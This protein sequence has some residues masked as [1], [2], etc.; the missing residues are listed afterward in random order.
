V[1]SWSQDAPCQ[2]LENTQ[3]QKL[4]EELATAKRLDVQPM[5]VDDPGFEEVANAGLVKWA[6]TEHGELLFVPHSVG[7]EE[8]A[9][10]VLTNG[11]PVL[12]AGV[13]DLAVDSHEIDGFLISNQSSHYLTDKKSLEIG[14]QAFQALGVTFRYVQDCSG[15]VDGDGQRHS[16][17]P[18]HQYEQHEDSPARDR[19]LWDLERSPREGFDQQASTN[20][21]SHKDIEL[22][23]ERLRQV[24]ADWLKAGPCKLL[25]NTQAQ[26]LSE[27]LETAKRLGVHPM[28]VDDPGFEEVANAGLIKWAVTQHGELLVMAHSVGTEEIAHPVLT[29]GE[30]VLAAGVAD[31]AVDSHGPFGFLISNQSRRS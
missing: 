3:A 4:S 13:A 1:D 9:H 20:H 12:A 16:S 11:E 24:G 31:L 29:N 25:E 23:S 26:K 27:D 14:Q 22:L 8:I 18:D 21:T 30:P 5:H 19:H 10:S 2:L 7:T 17:L 28:H 6:V 15:N